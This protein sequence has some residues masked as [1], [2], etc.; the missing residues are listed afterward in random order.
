V[1][2]VVVVGRHWPL[3]SGLGR[4]RDGPASPHSTDGQHPQ[5]APSKPQPTTASHNG[6]CADPLRTR[7]SRCTLTGLG[8]AAN[9]VDQSEPRRPGRYDG[10]EPSA[11]EAGAL[12]RGRLLTCGGMMLTTEACRVRSPRSG[13][14][15]HDPARFWRVRRSA[16]PGSKGTVVTATPLLRAER[17][18]EATS[19]A[20]L[21]DSG[22]PIAIGLSNFGAWWV[23]SLRTTGLGFGADPRFPIRTGMSLTQIECDDPHHD[24]QASQV[25][26]T[27]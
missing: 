6:G 18:V 3:V 16:P 23:R 17:L 24:C 7:V 12:P 15:P 2:L 26:T 1:R 5:C 4:P 19:A 21:H 8:H 11:W 20:V 13:W 25:G 22:R 27:M 10:A 9:A 14:R